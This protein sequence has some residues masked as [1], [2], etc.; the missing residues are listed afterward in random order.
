MT[1]AEDA[2]RVRNEFMNALVAAANVEYAQGR[3]PNPPLAPPPR[4]VRPAQSD[5]GFPEWPPG[6]PR[7]TPSLLNQF[8]PDYDPLAAL[9]YIA[10]T[11][12][13]RRLS[14][15]LRMKGIDAELF[16]PPTSLAF[17]R[18]QGA[19]KKLSQWCHKAGYRPIIEG[20]SLAVAKGFI[21][22]RIKLCIKHDRPLKEIA[23][24]REDFAKIWDSWLSR[25]AEWARHAFRHFGP[26]PF[27]PIENPWRQIETD[28]AYVSAHGRFQR[29]PRPKT[30]LSRVSPASR[31]ALPAG[32]RIASRKAKR[33]AKEEV[34]PWL[35]LVE[36]EGV[37]MTN[38]SAIARA[39]NERAFPTPREATWDSK[40][41]ARLKKDVGWSLR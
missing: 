24:F 34:L 16:G 39:F 30:R 2:R 35:R 22:A 3:F 33:V 17:Q 12:A 18:A 26:V 6:D 10:I 20:I 11:G 15:C 14:A 13:G 36:R 4:I 21:V 27:E 7:S 19:M 32:P 5:I 29:H 9:R 23:E 28:P 40:G 41:V 38:N 31:E 37:D 25:E 8:H 1:V